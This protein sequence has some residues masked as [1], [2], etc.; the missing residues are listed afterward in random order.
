MNLY[1]LI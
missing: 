1:E